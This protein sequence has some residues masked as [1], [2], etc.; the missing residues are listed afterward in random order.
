MEN[1]EALIMA[2]KE[3]G[4]EVNADKTHYMFMSRDLNAGQSY[5]IKVDNSSFEKEEFKYLGTS[6]TSQNYI[7]EEIKSRL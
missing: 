4:L 3:F 6:S 1:A 7:H 2:S 5:S